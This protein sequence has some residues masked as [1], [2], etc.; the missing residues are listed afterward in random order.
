MARFCPNC[1]APQ[2]DTARFCG[3]CGAQIPVMEAQ[4]PIN[5]QPQE[6]Y[7]AQPQNDY[8]PPV[9][10]KKSN[11]KVIGI[12]IGAVVLIAAIVIGLFAFGVFGDSKKDEESNSPEAVAEQ[13]IS[14]FVSGSA[15]KMANLYPAFMYDN[16]AEFIADIED[17]LNYISSI[18]KMGAN[19]SYS[20]GKSESVTG[21]DLTELKEDLEDEYGIDGDDITGCKKVEVTI[22]ISY[23][24]E[25][26]NQ[27]GEVVLIKYKGD[28]KV[29]YPDF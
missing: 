24:G 4:E 28:W 3:S 23:Q 17:N 16:K 1:G 13:F 14:A 11:K 27:D 7:F 22:K 26:Q 15:Q 19:L 18:K 25:S 21:E 20:V 6:N 5:P 9:A 2:E 12:V 8:V 10:P 29:I